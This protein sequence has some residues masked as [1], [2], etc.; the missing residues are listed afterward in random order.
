MFHVFYGVR[1]KIFIYYSDKFFISSQKSESHKHLN[2]IIHIFW[3]ANKSGEAI[4]VAP[5]IEK[6]RRLT[7]LWASTAYYRDS[8][9]F[10]TRLV[11]I[12]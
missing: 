9:T 10:F 3:L 6:P 12:T 2:N 4:C 7:T 5:S 11:Q 8:F 1:S